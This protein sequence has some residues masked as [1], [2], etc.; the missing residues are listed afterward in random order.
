VSGE[1][2]DHS[3]LHQRHRRHRGEEARVI[4]ALCAAVDLLMNNEL[5]TYKSQPQR[6]LTECVHNH[7]VKV[8]RDERYGGVAVA[9]FGVPTKLPYFEPG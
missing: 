7:I 9:S 1:Q 2:H 6:N 8:K 4:M 3:H 5:M